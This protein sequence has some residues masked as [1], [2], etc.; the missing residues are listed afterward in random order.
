MPRPR[1]PKAVIVTSPLPPGRSILERSVTVMP[2][3][4]DQIVGEPPRYNTEAPQ[5][6]ELAR[7]I[8]W[9]AR[10]EM[11]DVIAG[12]ADRKAREAKERETES[13]G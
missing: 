10:R 13:S 9:S 5:E 4:M 11:A 12:L 2:A 7:W 3:D 8:G 6:Q 1:G